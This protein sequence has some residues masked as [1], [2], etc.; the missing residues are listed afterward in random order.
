MSRKRGPKPHR[1]EQDPPDPVE[2]ASLDSFP[3]SDPPSWIPMHIGSPPSAATSATP[4]KHGS[5]LANSRVDKP[6]ASDPA[7]RQPPSGP[8][9][10][11]RVRPEP[12]E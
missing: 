8:A 9:I 12:K 2:Q 1:P 10:T 6:T 5:E 3:A 11:K 7:D 4:G